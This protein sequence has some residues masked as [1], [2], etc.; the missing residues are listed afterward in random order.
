MSESVSK[1]F[2]VSTLDNGLTLA[3]IESRHVPIVTTVLWFRVGAA[4]DAESEAGTAHFLEHMMFKGSAKFGAGEIDRL[5]QSLGGS[6]NA[7]TGHDSTAYHFQFAADRWPRA[8]EM[9]ADR[10]AGLLLDPRDFENERQVIVEEIAMYESEPWDALEAR[11]QKALFAGHPY[12]RPVLGTREE[13]LAM[14]PETLGSFHSSHYRPGNAVLVVA[15]D[16]GSEVEELVARSFGSLPSAEG[17]AQE[18]DPVAFP[19]ARKRLEVRRGE[20]PR[21]LFSLPAPP[22]S[23]PDHP[24]LRLLLHWLSVGRSS[25]L[26]RTLVEEEQLCAWIS[27]DLS[28]SSEPGSLSFSLELPGTDPELVEKRLFELLDEARKAAPTVSDLQ[29][30]KQLYRADWVFA[31]EHI[32]Q[33]ALMAASS[34]A[35]HDAGF[36]ER[37]RREVLDCSAD[38]VGD[39][40]TR[41]LDLNRGVVGWSLPS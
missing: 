11:V 4:A 21:L 12:G 14:T 2:R 33:R 3:V 41:Y 13:L 36:P 39:V 25:L 1:D 8:L 15:G 29:R 18:T 35:H 37:Y 19:E 38:D 10:M 6:N 40:A 16:V 9:E 31:H 7:F 22:C 27:A 23:H 34:I 30:A 17:C 32:Y 28:D 26:H 5:T 20:L 24:H